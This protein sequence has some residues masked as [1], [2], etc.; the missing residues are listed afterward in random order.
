LYGQ[1]LAAAG[2]LKG[3][4]NGELPAWPSAN[5]KK[6]LR[7]KNEEIKA[8]YIPNGRHSA[9]RVGELVSGIKM[10]PKNTQSRYEYIFLSAIQTNK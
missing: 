1:V 8:K 3:H 9:T 6:T 10:Q 5:K 4:Q 7:D 2:L